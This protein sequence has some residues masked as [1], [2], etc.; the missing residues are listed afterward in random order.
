LAILSTDSDLALASLKPFKVVWTASLAGPKFYMS[1][2]MAF[3]L[4]AL[5][6]STIGFWGLLRY[7]VQIRTKEIGIRIAL[8]ARP[9]T[10]L[11]LFAKQGLKL[12]GT[13]LAVGTLGAY[14]LVRFLEQMFYTPHPAAL[15]MVIKTVFPLGFIA[16]ASSVLTSV[17]AATIDPSIVLRND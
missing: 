7:Q 3:G 16:L 5:L 12:V 4:A 11:L 14:P 1:L 10:I 15:A 2:T 17:Q 13:G 8:G 9:S 6:L